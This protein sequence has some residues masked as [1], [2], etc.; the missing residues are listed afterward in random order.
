[1]RICMFI[2]NKRMRIM[3]GV[4]IRRSLR[5]RARPRPG[6]RPRP[7]ARQLVP[8]LG[9]VACSQRHLHGCGRQR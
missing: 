8:V 3:H 4:V 6:E 5:A 1:M 9:T 7:R 2:A